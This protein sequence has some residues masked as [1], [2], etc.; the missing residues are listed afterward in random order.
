MKQIVIKILVL[1]LPLILSGFSKSFPVKNH[2]Y[3]NLKICLDS[4]PKDTCIIYGMTFEI[5]DNSGTKGLKAIIRNGRIKIMATD[6]PNIKFRVIRY[7]FSITRDE[8][9]SSIRTYGDLVSFL[10]I[11]LLKD[12]QAGDL[13]NF[14]D[15]MI[16]D[17][18][19]EILD[20]AVK[21][22]IIK[23]L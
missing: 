4:I 15:I 8:K 12:A 16:V 7:V 14:E 21:P 23:K 2:F 17:P 5:V 13:F 18:N 10:V 6:K 19:K 11:D 9:T 22:I 1:V 3:H 20:N